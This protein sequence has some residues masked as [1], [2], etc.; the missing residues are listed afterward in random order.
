MLTSEGCAARRHR[1]W[2]ALPAPCDL[3]V[4]SDPQHLIYFANYES[5]HSRANQAAA[6]LVLEPDRATLVADSMLKPFCDQAHV[7]EVVAPDWYTGKA[8]APHRQG[9]LARTTLDTLARRP[10]RRIGVELGTV[11]GGVL[12]GLRNARTGVEFVDLDPIV[13]PLRRAKD[14]DELDVLRR[15]IRAGEAGH[16]AAMA[17]LRPGMTELQ[18]YLLVQS[19]ALE[20][21]GEPAVVYGDFASGPR[22]EIERGGPPTHRKIERGDLFLLD[23]SVILRGYRGDFT[24]TFAVGAKATARQRE[25]FEACLGA[26]RAGEAL[27]KP[28]TPGRAVD[29]AVHAHFRALGL[30]A[31]FPSH[32][33]HGI[34]LGHPDPPYLVPEITDS[35]IAGD[36]VTLEPGLYIR[37]EGGMRIEHNYRITA[38]GFETLT[39]HRLAIDVQE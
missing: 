23:Y 12:E 34:G 13:R 27:L 7:D 1:L 38:D 31:Y 37:G 2:N 21:L 16:A 33:G 36:V 22:C 39:H 15:S 8:S 4:I 14:A 29:E 9:F 28:G 25:L 18:A 6:L 32:S 19:A 24:N 5:W 17:E 3:L 10:G 26:L 11:P 30:D 20:D 35:L